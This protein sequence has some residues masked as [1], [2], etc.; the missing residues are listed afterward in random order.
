VAFISG[1]PIE[2][3]AAGSTGSPGS[4]WAWGS[5]GQ[6]QLGNG[7]IT[8]SSTPVAVSLPSGSTVT[9]IAGGSV[10]SLALTSSGQVLTWGDNAAG[11]LG[12]G[13]TSNSS[14]P[15]QVSLPSGTTVTA[16]AGAYHS[17]ALTSS[18]QVLAWGFNNYGQL[19]NGTTTNTG[20][21]CI[22]TPVAVS[23]PSGT[24]VTAI[25]GGDY[26]SL[27]L[28][29]SGQVLAW[30]DN[31]NGELGNGTTT[32]SSTPVQVSLPSGTTV[33]AIAGGS[34]HSL[35]LTSGG[36]VLAWGSNYYGELGNSTITNSSTPVQVSLPSGTTVIAIA[37]GGFHSLALTAS[38]QVLA[39]GHNSS[40]EL[41]N[42]T[43]TNSNTP[44][45]VSLPSGT[46]VTA[47]AAGSYHS[48]ALTSTGQV[49]AW[50]YNGSGQLGNGTTNSSST[51]VVVSAL[52]TVVTAI[53][54][55]GNHSLAIQLP[56]AAVFPALSNGAYGGYITTATIQ[57]AGSAPAVVHIAYFDQ[58]GAPVGAGDAINNLPV[59]ASWTVHQDNGN[60]FPSS[61]GDA[62]QAGSA[63]VYSSQ[64]VA[65]F[66]NEFAP[67][68]VGD[69]TS[70][71]GVEVASGVGTT[72]YAPTIVKS[73]Y[74]GYTTGVGLLNEGGSATDVTITY[75]DGGGALIKT[76]SVP[77]L[78]AHAYQALYSGDTTLA[79]PSG[80]AGTATITSSAGQPLAAVVNE[81]G[82]GG[83]FSS[84]DAVP[85]GGTAL[86][87]PVALNNAF[88]GYY[89]GMGIQ[90]TSA[91]SGT[92]TVT[93]YDTSGTPTVKSLSIPANGSLG[94]Y[95]GSPTDGPAVGAYT[96]TITST[97]AIAAIVNEVASSSTSVQQ[98]TS[99]NTFSAGSTTLHL[100]LV[101]NA[102]SDPWNTGEG[103]MNTGTASTTVTVTYYDT[104]TGAAVGTAQT[105]TLAPHAF[106]GLYQP[107]GGLPSGTR[108]TA[109][110]TTSSGGQVAV[111][112]N[113]SST[114]TFMSYDGQ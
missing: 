22:S 62:A 38:G 52:Q 92:V 36:Q 39:W 29:S 19:G 78:A 49:L 103:I 54:G 104:G 21:F 27:A 48:L 28:T 57:N 20:C 26:H 16:I 91:S 94:V 12:N 3:Q 47:I 83:Q 85:A 99:Y 65:T 15:V 113:E 51:P 73:A 41:G 42:G 9:A 102:G 106:W 44:V 68:N 90:N 71:S 86:N 96:A 53:A 84:Y 72:L 2:T 30:G 63:V 45:Q 77:A 59:N 112:C 35:A 43:T 18:G 4:A 5:N 97:V 31:Y 60:S 14:T 58:N 81:V 24:T 61:G 55:G 11:E 82:P 108:A 109:V 1:P 93:Y 17:L 46:T 8:N 74:G 25:A 79:L 110:V 69:A 105:Q 87:A 13:T 37:A 66:V 76:Q 101:E 114:T 33:T 32:N 80:F 107:T 100:P 67:G 23:L 10:H 50:G 56:A 6:G 7:T 95:Q 75:R 89:T 98:S 64:P 70:Y 34:Y 111:I 40:G 88:G